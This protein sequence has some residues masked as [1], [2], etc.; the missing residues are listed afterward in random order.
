M[1]VPIKRLIRHI[2]ICPAPFNIG[3]DGADIN[4][5]NINEATIISKPRNTNLYALFDFRS[6]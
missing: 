5:E 3:A 4:T 6:E 1:S 2:I